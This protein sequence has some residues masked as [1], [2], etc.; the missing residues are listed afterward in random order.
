M[1]GDH[2]LPGRPC[3]VWLWLSWING[4]AGEGGRRDICSWEGQ[5]QL[6]CIE[7]IEESRSKRGCWGRGVLGPWDKGAHWMAGLKRQWLRMLELIGLWVGQ[8]RYR[9]FL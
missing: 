5:L 9:C 8:S 1:V 3:V 6:P 7:C 4:M 2:T